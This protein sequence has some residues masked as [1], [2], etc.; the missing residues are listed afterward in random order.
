MAITTVTVHSG[1]RGRLVAMTTSI[2]VISRVIAEKHLK[3]HTDV[4]LIAFGGEEQGEEQGR[5]GSIAYA[6][7]Y[8]L[9]DHLRAW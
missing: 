8:S 1:A 6:R 4:E 7:E 3:F 5:P 2:L 9:A